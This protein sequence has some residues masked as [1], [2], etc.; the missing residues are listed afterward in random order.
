M[1]ERI[2]VDASCAN[3]TAWVPIDG[4]TAG[5]CQAHPPTPLYGA[6]FRQ[7]GPGVPELEYC[8]P[9]TAASDWCREFQKITA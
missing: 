6:H 8:F 4:Q 3:C 9:I 7:P 5:F 2:P 1:A